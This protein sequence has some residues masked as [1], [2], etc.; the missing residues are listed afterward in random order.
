MTLAPSTIATAIGSLTIVYLILFVHL[1]IYLWRFHT[2]VWVEL[3]RPS[4]NL[5]FF[6]NVPELSRSIQ[7]ASLTCRFVLLD[8]RYKL[9][10]DNQLSTSVFLIR[11]VALFLVLSWGL[12]FASA[13]LFPAADKD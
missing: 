1:L 8:N 7:T 6:R 12:L 11:I 2:T 10:G 5:V 4:P 13:F 3:G 9:L